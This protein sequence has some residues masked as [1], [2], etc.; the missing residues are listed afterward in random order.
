MINGTVRAWFFSILLRVVAST[1]RGRQFLL[2]ESVDL[3][4]SPEL[5]AKDFGV[6]FGWVIGEEL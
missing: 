4:I 2:C 5:L 6:I 1:Q 3:A